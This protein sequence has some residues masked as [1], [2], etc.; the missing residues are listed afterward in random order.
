MRIPQPVWADVIFPRIAQA[1][2]SGR[3]DEIGIAYIRCIRGMVPE[4]FELWNFAE[5]GIREVHPFARV[6]LRDNFTEDTF[7]T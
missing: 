1:I 2:R 5:D 4:A 3:G 7:Y 6:Q